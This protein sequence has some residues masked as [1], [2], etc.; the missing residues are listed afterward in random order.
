MVHILLADD[1]KPVRDN[2]RSLISQHQ[3]YWEVSEAANGQEAIEQ[4]RRV[5]PDVVVLDIV[6]MP[7]G[8]VAAAHE[9]RRI[10]PEA[11]IIFISGHY[12]PGEA[13]VVTRLLGAGAF[14]PKVDAVKSLIPTIKRLL[15]EETQPV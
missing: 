14:V 3:P 6:M 9:I 10:N 1:H 11:K 15:S 2:L 8:G 4:F 12:A 13:A 5:R 7:V